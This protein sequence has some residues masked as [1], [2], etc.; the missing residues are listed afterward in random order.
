MIATQYETIQVEYGKRAKLVLSD[1][2]IIVADAGSE[3]RYPT[4]FS[5]TR[6]IY[7]KGEAYFQVAKD[8]RHHRKK[9]CGGQ[10]APELQVQI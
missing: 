8:P 1:G 7:L 3:I 9:R 10:L 6:D 5:E 2:S 4:V